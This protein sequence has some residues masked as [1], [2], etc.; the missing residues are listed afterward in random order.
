MGWGE[1]ILGQ[2]LSGRPVVTFSLFWFEL[3]AL[4]RGLSNTWSLL[5]FQN[6]IWFLKENPFG[7]INL[8]SERD[9]GND[10]TRMDS[11]VES[12][13]GSMMELRGEVT[14][15]KEEI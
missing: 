4:R 2:G 13:E 12:V 14:T 11:R 1:A 10:D 7:S 5:H 15:L 8:I 3:C 6:N 9:L